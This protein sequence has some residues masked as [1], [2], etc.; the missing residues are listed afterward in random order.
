MRPVNL[1]PPED[2]KRGGGGGAGQGARTGPAA[3]VLV[4]SLAIIMGGLAY[5]SLLGNSIGE[6]KDEVAALEAQ[7]ASARAR[8]DSLR[9]FSDFR[10]RQERR[11]ISIASLAQSRFDWERVMREMAVTIP[12]DIWLIEMVGE[13]VDPTLDGTAANDP[14]APPAPPSVLVKGCGPGHRSVAAY[15]ASLHDVD[16]VSDVAIESSER[17]TPSDSDAGVSQDSGECRTRDFIS[18]FSIRVLFEAEEEPVGATA[19]PGVPDAAAPPAGAQADSQDSDS[20]KTAS[21][22][23]PVPAGVAR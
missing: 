11:T 8:A 6:K 19:A 13:T 7:E 21:K 3:Y 16:G 17:P 23:T 5:S 22:G 20:D 1:I 15:A 12:S 14:T 4:G 10:A 18:Q 2:R 9:A